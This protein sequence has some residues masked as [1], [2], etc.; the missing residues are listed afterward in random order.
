MAKDDEKKP[1]FAEDDG[2]NFIVEGG[3]EMKVA[4][5]AEQAGGEAAAQEAAAEAKE[6]PAK[7]AEPKEAE[8]A[9][10]AKDTPFKDLPEGMRKRIARAN[11]QRDEAQADLAALKA[12]GE[13]APAKEEKELNPDDFDSFDEFLTARDGK[14]ETKKAE[15]KAPK[16]LDGVPSADFQP[17]LAD[18]KEKVETEDPDLW[19]KAASSKDLTISA[20]LV[21]AMNEAENPAA[22]LEHLVANPDESKKLSGMTP[23]GQAKAIAKLEGTVKA[24]TK[25]ATSAPEPA[26]TTQ[27]RGISPDKTLGEMSQKEFEKARNE[28][29]RGGGSHWL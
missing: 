2:S 17:V 22:I 5:A 9:E 21:M 26:E 23:F 6:A 20:P 10:G 25:K 12:K 18:L 19:E 11:R 1:D 3:E 8:E 14:P 15:E 16:Y 24:P 28:Q 4:E 29:E 13:D 7:E 27:A